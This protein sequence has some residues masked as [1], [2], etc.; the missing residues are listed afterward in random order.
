MYP[1][2]S[3]VPKSFA[4]WWGGTC[5]EITFP[6]RGGDM[7]PAMHCSTDD[8]EQERVPAVLLGGNGMNEYSS[9]APGSLSSL[10]AN[11]ENFS[12]DFFSL[13][14][15]GKQYA[16]RT[17]SMSQ[18]QSLDDAVDLVSFISNSTRRR[19]VLFGWSLGTAVAAGLAETMAADVRCII[20]GN[21]FTDMH[22]EA[23]AVLRVPLFLLR[24]WSMLLDPWPTLRWARDF[25][26]P[27]IVMSSA[28]DELIPAAMHRAVYDAVG[29][30]QKDFIERNASHMDFRAFSRAF[31][32]SVSHLC[33]A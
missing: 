14:Y 4:T 12:W 18:D 5:I 29:S 30:R 28:K 31:A 10:L 3:A 33:R 8:R 20:L 19:V 15:S 13:S 9:M 2:D 7:V 21:P 24:P 22:S 6:S 11:V 23:A 25:Q 26:V 17:G 32:T 16:P 1:G 27:T